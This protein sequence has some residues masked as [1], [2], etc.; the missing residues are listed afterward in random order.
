MRPPWPEQLVFP[1]RVASSFLFRAIS[2]R[3]QRESFL[4]TVCQFRTP[5]RRDAHPPANTVFLGRS[6]LRRRDATYKSV[7][8]G[9]NPILSGLKTL[10]E[11]GKPLVIARSLSGSGMRRTK[12]GPIG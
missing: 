9:W 3:S 11:T 7:G 10:L 8:D 6:R 2:S 12:V 1:S 5:A 4:M